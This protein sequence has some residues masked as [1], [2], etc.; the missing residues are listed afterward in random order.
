MACDVTLPVVVSRSR[1]NRFLY[2]HGC[3]REIWK[4]HHHRPQ[5]PFR[6]RLP[7]PA[8]SG[9]RSTARRPNRVFP[10][11]L[12]FALLLFLQCA[13]GAPRL[14]VPLVFEPSGSPN[15]IVAREPGF[16]ATI[17]PTGATYVPRNGYGEYTMQFEG[18]NKRARMVPRDRLPGISSYFKGPA[19]RWRLGVP[20]Y[21]RVTAEAVYPG[22]DVAW[23]EDSGKLEYDFIVQP[24]GD[25][26][27]ICLAFR[28]ASA[29]QVR[30]DGSLL[31]SVKS[32]Q[33]EQRKPALYQIEDGRRIAV[34]GR[35]RLTGAHR[36]AFETGPYNHSLPLIIDPA[37]DFATLLGGSEFD[38][39]VGVTLDAGKNIYVT[40]TTQS[41]DFPGTGLSPSKP[42]SRQQ[43]VFVT[44]MDPQAR[45]ILYSVFIGGSSMDAPAGIAVDSG[46]S[47]YVAGTTESTDFPTSSCIG[48]S[49]KSSQGAFAF[50]LNAA[51]TG[52][53]WSTCL[54]T[55]S[56]AAANGIALTSLGNLVV[57]GSV[58][59]AF[60]V[61]AGAA[62]AVLPVDPYYSQVTQGFAAELNSA[63]SAFVYATYL[64]GTRETVAR[65]AALDVSG[66]LFVTGSTRAKD[67]PVTAGAYQAVNNSGDSGANA[68][69]TKINAA[70][71]AFVY[72]TYLGGQGSDVGLA[73]AADAAGN[74]YVTGGANGGSSDSGPPKPFPTTPGV[75]YP[76]G[77][78]SS[79]FLTKM[80]PS[81]TALVYSTYLPEAAFYYSSNGRAIA[82]NPDGS[83]FVA[84][85]SAQGLSFIGSN[86]VA[87]ALA[88][89]T[90]VLSVNNDATRI[91]DSQF[92]AD[93]S[94]SGMWPDGTS[95]LIAG[96]TGPGAAVA[97]PGTFQENLKGSIAG[98]VSKIDFDAGNL[99]TL[100]INAQNLIFNQQI[101]PSAPPVS[102]ITLSLTS[103]GAPIPFHLANATTN[104]GPSGLQYTLSFSPTDGITPAQVVV[105]PA[106]LQSENLS[107]F[108]VLAPGATNGDQ[109]IPVY[110]YEQ[111][112]S[113]VATFTNSAGP[114]TGLTFGFLDNGGAAQQETMNLNA[115]VPSTFRYGPGTSVVLPYLVTSTHPWLTVQPS[116][117]FT[118]AT[119]TFTANP[120]GLANGNY[121][122]QVMIESSPPH[123]LAKT[124]FASMV[125]GPRLVFGR[126]QP[127][128]ASTGGAAVSQTLAIASNGPAIPFTVS[129]PA[130]PWLSVGSLSGTTP[131]SITLTA[132]PAGIS[133]GSYST[134]LSV[135]GAGIS[136]SISVVFSVTASGSSSAV[137][138]GGVVSSAANPYG[139]GIAAGSLASVYGQNFTDSTEQAIT[140]PLPSQLGGVG[141]KIG[142]YAAPL[143]FVSPSQI[144][145]EVPSEVTPGNATVQISGPSGTASGTVK[146]AESQP[147]MFV[148]YAASS[149]PIIVNAEGSLNDGAHP[150]H[151]GDFIV[152]YMTGQ[153]PLDRRVPD[154]AAAPS[155]PP[156]R[157]A[158]PV[159]VTIGGLNAPVAFAGLTP[160]LAGLFQVNVQVPVIYSGIHGLVVTVGS[161][162]SDIFPIT[163]AN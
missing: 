151:P 148:N 152:L 29:L 157:A 117:G 88:V 65:A 52:L 101:F 83:V 147:G 30:P 103:T 108:S 3:T 40:G 31:I 87:P 136:Y 34:D 24:G 156:A 69:V 68:F 142:G 4:L 63:G 115:V 111:S 14:Q 43:D 140:L 42:A 118:P 79:G 114:A 48:S 144:N 134:K 102:P 2:R 78:S 53:S 36:V 72:S 92:I 132:N 116:S 89:G 95:V 5:R 45:T 51:G 93:V 7:R 110:L 124:I 104:T 32:G 141:V 57:V 8:P 155:D 128:Q 82:L 90:A 74:A 162:P 39:A 59:G 150:A 64:A 97:T 50:K 99:P 55:N 70:G 11:R 28:G 127:F 18:A 21:A 41:A 27:R 105:T 153:G 112:P 20:Q 98:F 86:I 6:L 85:G 143:L 113:L 94:A 122:A 80:N 119:V 60:P 159:S 145:L 66:N 100:N 1:L 10:Q 56:S 67:F 13:S 125:I 58:T 71:S 44:K 37:L 158:L 9:P 16:A 133:A 121:I 77:S 154:G 126:L 49:N 146:I 139:T 129:S 149:Q 25:A 33:S 61:T 15:A 123:Y 22:I 138:I 47:A 160:T 26:A 19:A 76:T 131:A 163:V 54:T 107:H 84:Q 91:V 12:P 38:S 135:S 130:V 161:S 96:R 46:G 73:I 75:V 35:F 81:G 62:Q 106:N 23:H 137:S 17:R 109:V 120:A